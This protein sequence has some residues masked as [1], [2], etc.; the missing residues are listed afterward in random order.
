[1]HQDLNFDFIIF[2]SGTV[3]LSIQSIADVQASYQLKTC[4]VKNIGQDLVRYQ[5]LN[6]SQ[7]GLGLHGLLS[8]Q[9]D[10][11]L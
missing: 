4:L 11:V 8:L 2:C 5:N 1:M 6:R 9:A 7:L 3:L 10:R